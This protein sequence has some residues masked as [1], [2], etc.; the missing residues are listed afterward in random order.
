MVCFSE[1]SYNFAFTNKNY[2]Q[3]YVFEFTRHCNYSCHRNPKDL[4]KV[5]HFALTQDISTP[6]R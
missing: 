3:V 6:F 4:P 1:K 2:N 5:G